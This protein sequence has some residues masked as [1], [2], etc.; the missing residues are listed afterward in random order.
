MGAGRLAEVG[1]VFQA[2]SFSTPSFFASSAARALTTRSRTRSFT[3]ANGSVRA[4]V[5]CDTRP[6]T[7]VLGAISTASVLRFFWVLSG[8]NSALRN[9]GLARALVA[10]A[11]GLR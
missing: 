9:F 11:A 4:G 3:S 6:A 10:P 2:A 8:E 1:L 7:K 5:Y